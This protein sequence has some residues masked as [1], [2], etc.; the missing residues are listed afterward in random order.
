MLEPTG[1]KLKIKPPK[2]ESTTDICQVG[3]YPNRSVF[4][5]SAS[6]SCFPYPSNPI[7]CVR[8]YGSWF[9]NIPTWDECGWHEPNAKEVKLGITNVEGSGVRHKRH[10]QIQEVTQGEIKRTEGVGNPGRG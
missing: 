1:G 7:M 4:S 2:D 5:P 8:E 10:I 3:I 6:L 9:A